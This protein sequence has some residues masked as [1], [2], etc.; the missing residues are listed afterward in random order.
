MSKNLMPEI[1]K[2]LGVENN[3]KFQVDTHGTEF[4]KGNLFCFNEK[5]GLLMVDPDGVVCGASELVYGILCGYY[6]IV[7]LPWE[8][9]YGDAYYVMCFRNGTKPNIECYKWTGCAEDYGLL[10]LGMAYRTQEA[11][12]A[13]MS[14][15][16][17]RLTGKPL[18]SVE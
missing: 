4:A 7:K 9:K 11:A 2:M 1:M 10:K 15:D 13:H 18:S 8:P 3:E 17:E 5:N 14:E 16:Y 12:E 6:T